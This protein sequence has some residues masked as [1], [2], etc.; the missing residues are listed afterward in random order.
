MSV[1]GDRADTF[2]EKTSIIRRW[3]DNEAVPTAALAEELHRW[4]RWADRGVADL[5]PPAPSPVEGVSVPL[6]EWEA[7]REAVEANNIVSADLS[8]SSAEQERSAL[9][10]EDAAA[11]LVAA[12]DRGAAQPDEK[13]ECPECRGCGKFGGPGSY[14]DHPGGK[15]CWTCDGTGA[16]R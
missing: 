1:H 14:Y 3:L 9:R 6:P 2:E 15:P 13:G 16:S 10:V 8:A 12:A 5:S 4:A 11:A 7:L